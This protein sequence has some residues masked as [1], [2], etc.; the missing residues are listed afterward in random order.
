MMLDVRA[1]AARVLARVITGGHSLA[2]A[3]PEGME[4][5]A[6]GRQRALLQELS[7][8]TLRWYFRLDA[9]LAQLLRRPLKQRDADVYC[10]LLTGLYQLDQLAM[11]QRVAV[12]ETVQ[13]VRALDKSWAS[14]LVNGVMRNYQRRAAEIEPVINTQAQARHAHPGWLIENLQADWP[15]DWTAILAAN[16]RRPPLSLRV[17]RQRLTRA[18]YLE[19]LSR[20]GLEATPLIA[21]EGILLHKPVAVE[22]LPGF[23]DGFVS[24]QDG[25]AQLAAGLLAI[26]AGQRVL[27]ACAAPGGK[28]AH[29]LESG[30]E[31]AGLT[32]IDID[33]S[34]LES[35]A[36]NLTRLGLKADLVA[37]DAAMP[38]TWWDGVFYDRI[39]LDAP[40]TATGVIRRHP[41][42]KI[43]RKPGDVMPLVSRQQVLLQSLWPLLSPGGM[44]L[45]CTCS[46]LAAEN[47]DQ[48]ERFLA[49]H[50][51]AAEIP[52]NSSWGHACK[53]G[54]QLLP[55]DNE[56]DGFYFACLHKA[57]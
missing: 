53:H 34:R 21:P 41:D 33:D 49:R 32:A 37:A 8:G 14:G 43:L 18:E 17:N 50:A 28:T 54:R 35:V 30:I 1:R 51:D 15:E 38:A 52:V 56:M 16:N 19:I 55:G 6:D 48:I 12:H 42:I 44:L 11:P 7:Y 2:A 46:V 9:I 45:Y 25:A 36:E 27:D 40:C 31:L 57:T 13:A 23:T 22:A 39:L 10:L 29:I 4:S 20:H 5:L 47:S 24:V 3:L 26:E